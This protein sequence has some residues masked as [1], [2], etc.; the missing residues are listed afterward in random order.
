MQFVLHV[1]GVVYA[2]S[3]VV[4]LGGGLAFRYFPSVKRSLIGDQREG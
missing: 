1:V 2:A 3:V 4:M